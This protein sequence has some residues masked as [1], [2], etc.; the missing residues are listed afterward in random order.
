[1]FYSHAPGYMSFS[2]QKLFGLNWNGLPPP[3]VNGSKLIAAVYYFETKRKISLNRGEK[4]PSQ[5]GSR[6]NYTH[7]T[8]SRIRH[9]MK[10]DVY[11]YCVKLQRVSMY[12]P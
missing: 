8:N 3:A 11:M 4:Y 7:C 10:C 9:V 5:A 12:S 6:N 1:M 2:V